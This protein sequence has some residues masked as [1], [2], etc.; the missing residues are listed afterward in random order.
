VGRDFDGCGDEKDDNAPSF[1]P[2]ITRR[3]KYVYGTEGQGTRTVL[4]RFGADTLKVKTKKETQD[5]P[6][7]NQGWGTLRVFVSA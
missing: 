4:G 2:K 1:P 3:L 7:G 6:F 5:P